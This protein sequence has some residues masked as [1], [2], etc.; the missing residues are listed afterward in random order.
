L[1]SAA[2]GARDFARTFLEEPLPDEMRFRIRLN[3]SCDSHF[4]FGVERIFPEDSSLARAEELADCNEEQVLDTLWRNG[5]VPEWINVSVIGE[6]GTTTMLQLICCGRFV[7]EHR[8]LYHEG[9]GIPP[10]HVL[11]PGLPADY[12]EGRR[13]SI[14]R[15]AECMSVRD[16]EQ[17]RLH[18][19]KV[20]SVTLVGSRLGDRV[21]AELPE[22]AAMESIEL[23]SSSIRGTSLLEL[24]RFPR[25]QV[26]RLRLEESDQFTL[27]TFT[28]GLPSLEIFAIDNAP[29]RPWGLGEFLG[30][31]PNLRCL[32]IEAR[33]ELFLEGTCPREMEDVMVSARRLR[34]LLKLPRKLRFL[35]AHV[36]EMRER[37]IE[38]WLS[39]VAEVRR[40][41]LS[42]MP[43]GDELAEA[44]AARLGLAH[45]NL[46]GTGVSNEALK[47]IANAHP[48]LRLIPRL[49]RGARG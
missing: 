5:R 16:F 14:N 25:L 18:A 36:A 19:D 43:I 8:L 49:G 6:S 44:L 11:G 7:R 4:Q 10:F 3:R 32:T 26:V 9:E 23:K 35:L 48:K 30:V 12:E 24:H 13:F 20:Q 17:L 29:P 42:G 45:L 40:L 22:L 31:V 28:D 33:D 27:P 37:E 38:S 41:D 39:D 2:T 21:L 15:H 47:R 1:R 46:A 34:G